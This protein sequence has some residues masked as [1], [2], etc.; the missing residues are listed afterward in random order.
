MTAREK[1]ADMD[2]SCS[3]CQYWQAP[4]KYEMH[5]T[6][7]NS[8]FFEDSWGSCHDWYPSD[9]ALARYKAKKKVK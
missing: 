7:G 9:D 2:H 1:Y 8:R 6:C 4:T 5:G 3:N